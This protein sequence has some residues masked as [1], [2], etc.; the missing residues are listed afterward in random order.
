MGTANGMAMD[1]NAMNQLAMQSNRANS[2]A[3]QNKL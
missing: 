2:Q 1:A 3:P